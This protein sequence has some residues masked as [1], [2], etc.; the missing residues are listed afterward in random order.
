MAFG[1]IS[2]QDLIDAGLDPD[3]LAEFQ[4]KGVTKDELATL[5]T[6]IE[7]NVTA[8]IQE[9]FSGLEAKLTARP[10]A[11]S[12][13]RTDTNADGTPKEKPKGILDFDP[14]DFNMNPAEHLSKITNV[15]LMDSRIQNMDI[16]RDNAYDRAQ[17][18]LP[19][20]KN[21]TIKAEIDTEW[22]KY[23]SQVLVNGSSDPGIVIK[24]VHD[25]VMGAHFNEI[26]TDSAKKEGKFNLVQTGGS[27]RSDNN[28]SGLNNKKTPEELLTPDELKNATSFGMTPQEWLDQKKD[29]KGYVQ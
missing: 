14:L 3:K 10:N 28:N 5:G 13:R 22:A 11:E 18:N 1:K 7:T 4:A 2:K 26:Q 25:S 6:T 9:M 24:K 23:T 19:G 29:I 17:N 15:L 16:R 20:F 27:N 8:K 12:E 21:E